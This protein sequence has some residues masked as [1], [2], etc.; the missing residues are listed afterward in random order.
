MP[1]W[2][3]P[4]EW[5]QARRSELRAAADA[6]AVEALQTFQGKGSVQALATAKA[7]AARSAARRR[8]YPVDLDDDGLPDWLR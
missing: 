8:P 2:P 5:W 6:S 4:R 7:A 3:L 1:S